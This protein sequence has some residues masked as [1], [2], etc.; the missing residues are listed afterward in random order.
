MKKE[1]SGK[2]SLGKASTSAF[3]RHKDDHILVSL[4]SVRICVCMFNC[5]F[6]Q[7]KVPVFKMRKE[8][9]AG[10]KLQFLSAKPIKMMTITHLPSMQPECVNWMN[11]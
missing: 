8:N 11:T 10:E 7:N 1:R 5:S 3:K 2:C 4:F 6:S 9:I